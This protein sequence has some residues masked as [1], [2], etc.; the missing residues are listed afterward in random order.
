LV[1]VCRHK[2]LPQ[3]VKA[4]PFFRRVLPEPSVRKFLPASRNHTFIVQSCREQAGDHSPDAKIS[5][6]PFGV[7]SGICNDA[8]HQFSR[9][10]YRDD[11]GGLFPDVVVEY[12]GMDYDDPVGIAFHEFPFFLAGFI[13]L[14]IQTK[15]EAD[16][17]PAYY[18]H[19]AV[20]FHQ[21]F[22]DLY[23][24]LFLS[25]DVCPGVVI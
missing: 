10:P 5:P 1:R 16:T 3:A 15:G 23:P 24:S 2:G 19:A 21:G 7:F 11:A 20:L 13:P 18:Y 25:D 17:G 6:L 8:V 9:H 22:L 12:R 14:A 4:F